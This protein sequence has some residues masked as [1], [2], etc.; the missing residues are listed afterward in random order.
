MRRRVL[1]P[2]T[3]A[4][5]GWVNP[6][7]LPKG[8]NGRALCRRCGVEV[9]VGRQTFC[10]GRC[11]TF[12]HD[13]SVRAEGSGCVHEHCIRSRPV[14]ARRCV[15]ARDRG[16]CATCGKVCRNAGSEWQADHIVPVVEGGGSCG[17]EGLRTLC[18]ACHREATKALAGRRA[19]A[20][21]DGS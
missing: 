19:Q 4:S 13:G 18:T 10:S 7:S 2:R 11:T 5:A 3:L 20:R 15:W 16:L 21:R 1:A 6:S 8:P 17:L 12:R 14:Y 9:P